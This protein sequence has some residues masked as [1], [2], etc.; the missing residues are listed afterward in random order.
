MVNIFFSGGAA[1]T[2]RWLGINGKL[3]VNID[4][5]SD[6][7]FYLHFGNITDP[8]SVKTRQEYYE[9]LYEGCSDEVSKEIRR[10]NRLLK[11]DNEICIWYSSKNADE[12]LGM[13][14]VVEKYQDKII[15]LSDCSNICEAIPLIDEDS[16]FDKP[17]KN[18][19]TEAQLK[20]ITEL[21][22]EVKSKNAALRIVE[23]GVI[24]NYPED[25][26]DEYIYKELGNEEKRAAN[27][28][29]PILE[30]YSRVYGFLMYRLHQ[31]V[32]NGEIIILQEGYAHNGPELV[33]DFLKSTIKKV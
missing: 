20:K 6:L 16:E 7:D 25:F 8:F 18:L 13:L 31:L 5:M 30:R 19:I 4:K 33:K 1:G 12:Y 21:W 26:L 32:D 9:P 17:E 14:A 24:N 11:N 23:N 27:I 29:P 22:N 10:L 15:W 2:V 28:F 3:D